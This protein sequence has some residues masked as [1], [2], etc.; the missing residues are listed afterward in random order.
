MGRN[1]R[2]Y[3]MEF[4]FLDA[5]N[6]GNAFGESK[7]ASKHNENDN[8]Q[9]KFF[10]PNTKENTELLSK[11]F[12]KFMKSEFREI[13]RAVDIK[14]E[15]VQSF[16]EQKASN[17]CNENTIY[18]YRSQLNKLNACIHERYDKSGAQLEK[19]ETVMPSKFENFTTNDLY[20][21]KLRDIFMNPQDLALVR[22]SLED[23]NAKTA[24][25]E[26]LLI[27][28]ALGCR[29]AEVVSIRAWQVDL[30]KHTVTIVQH[31]GDTDRGPKTG[32]GRVVS[33]DSKFDN[34]FKELLKDK[35]K[36]DRLCDVKPESLH[37]AWEREIKDHLAKDYPHLMEYIQHQTSFHAIRKENNDTYRKEMENQKFKELVDKGVNENKARAEAKEFSKRQS[38]LRL[39]HSAERDNLERVYNRK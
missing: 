6:A 5:L 34:E 24:L 36:D 37:R 2:G 15:H 10:N 8:T 38:M 7:H 27:A 3:N 14:T 26:G 23:R 39:G 31:D 35:D 9:A 18:N 1:R 13:K 30:E 11:D 4:Q 29:V 21:N 22:Q 25:R 20:D 19:W 33:F 16:L 28:D 32:R 12:A 17:G